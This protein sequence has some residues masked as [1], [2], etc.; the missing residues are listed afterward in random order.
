MRGDR[1][2][3]TCQAENLLAAVQGVRLER[4]AEAVRVQGLDCPAKK[5]ELYPGGSRDPQVHFKLGK[6]VSY[7]VGFPRSRC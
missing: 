7:Q 3:V 4:Q 1:K 6:C 5:Q 2:L